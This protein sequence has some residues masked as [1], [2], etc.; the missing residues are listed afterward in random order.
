M[1]DLED[2]LRTDG[3]AWQR[4]V[5]GG[6]RNCAS[7][8]DRG[9]RRPGLVPAL[10]AV[11]VVAIM[12]TIALVVRG[13]S[14]GSDS[15]SSG[16]AQPQGVH[17]F[18]RLTLHY[19]SGWHAVA[20]T[21]TTGAGTQPLGYV[22]STNPIPQCRSD[23]NGHVGCGAPIGALT[24]GASAVVANETLAPDRLLV[25]AEVDGW[26]AHRQLGDALCL[27]GAAY[28]STVEFVVSPANAIE[29][30][31][32]TAGTDRHAHRVVDRIVTTLQYRDP[33]AVTVSG[34]L[35]V[36]AGLVPDHSS[37]GRIE[38]ADASGGP[39][40]VLSTSSTGRYSAKVPPGRYVI[41]GRATGIHI[42]C[43]PGHVVAAS[44]SVAADVIC[45]GK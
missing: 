42:D 45:A 19:P 15:V 40:L 44:H 37:A 39:T 21:F 12:A 10:S 28:G 27:D 20:P 38:V 31:A 9:P 25:N 33:S 41:T 5:D 13:S 1:T 22:V 18:G 32:C 2:R 16:T 17:T 43:A 6:A 8:A 34:R 36:S 23:S 30:M 3:A 26:P 35:I 11:A 29:V 24:D 7:G 14:T 4:L